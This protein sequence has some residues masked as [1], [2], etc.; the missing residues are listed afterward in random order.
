MYIIMAGLCCFHW[1]YLLLESTW[2]VI[3]SVFKIFSHFDHVIEHF[4][5]HNGFSVRETLQPFLICQIRN[6]CTKYVSFLDI[7][8]T[9]SNVKLMLRLGPKWF[10]GE[11]SY[12]YEGGAEPDDCLRLKKIMKQT[13]SKGWGFFGKCLTLSRLKR[14][15][16]LWPF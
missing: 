6:I 3:F 12:Y 5:N 14:A 4:E 11:L 16:L 13:C 2:K 9:A 7:S 10:G 1:Y 8:R 15:G